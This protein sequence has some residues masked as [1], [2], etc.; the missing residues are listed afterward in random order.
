MSL[1]NVIHDLEKIGGRKHVTIEIY[2][3]YVGKIQIPFYKLKLSFNTTRPARTTHAGRMDFF[4]MLPYVHRLKPGA[5][6]IYSLNSFGSNSG[7]EG[8]ALGLRRKGSYLKDLQGPFTT[9][10]FRWRFAFSRA[11][12]LALCSAFC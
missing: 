6:T 10:R 5:L 12:S 4:I 3:T 7:R 8:G 11:L 2:F 1:L 9:M